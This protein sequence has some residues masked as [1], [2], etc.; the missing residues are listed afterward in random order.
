MNQSLALIA[1]AL[2]R[3]LTPVRIIVVVAV[4]AFFWFVVMGDQGLYQLER[5]LH[6][7]NRL[8]QERQNLNDAIDALTQE[9][10][11]LAD[12][13][14]LEPVIRDELGAIKP[15]EVIFEEKKPVSP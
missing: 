7:R 11:D 3:G 5:L 8:Q 1:A 9:K 15:G 10:A 6:M 2:L 14:N 13:A 4:C 12:P